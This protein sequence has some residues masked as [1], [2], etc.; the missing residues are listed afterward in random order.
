MLNIRRIRLAIF[1][2][3][4]ITLFLCIALFVN[5]DHKFCMD[6]PVVDNAFLEDLKKNPQLEIP[7]LLL[8]GTKDTSGKD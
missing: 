7:D 1:L 6:V 2:V 4:L 8:N 5:K 3:F